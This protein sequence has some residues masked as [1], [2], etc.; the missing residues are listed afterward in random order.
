MRRFFYAITILFSLLLLC[1]CTL[2]KK[3]YVQNEVIVIKNSLNNYRLTVENFENNITQTDAVW[4]QTK[5]VSRLKVSI[6]NN[7]EDK[8]YTETYLSYT[9]LDKKNKQLGICTN[10]FTQYEEELDPLN[11]EP[12]KNK[13]GYVYCDTTSPKIKKVRISVI[14]GIDPEAEKKGNFVGTGSRSYYVVLD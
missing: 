11:Q 8:Q 13:D 12:S 4:N 6:Q 5:K 1:G 2:E 9:L 14:T 7:E 3:E 10:I